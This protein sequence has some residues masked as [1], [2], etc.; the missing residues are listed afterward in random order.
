M[1][2]LFSLATL[3]G[4][5]QVSESRFLLG[6]FNPKTHPDFIEIPDSLCDREGLTLQKKVLEAYYL[7]YEAAKADSIELVIRSAT[8][9]FYYQKRIWE[10]KWTGKR[11]VKGL[12][13]CD[14]DR[15]DEDRA[16]II[17]RYS[18]MPGTSRH[19]WG[20]EI[21]LNNFSNGYF[22][23]GEGLRIY[24]WLKT[25][26]TTYGFYQ[27]YTAKD[28]DR[29]T[30]YEEE[31]WHWSYFPLSDEYT[32]TYLHTIGDQQISGFHGDYTASF[33]KVIENYVKG[34]AKSP[35]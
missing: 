3:S 2:L 26:A 32:H 14:L 35:K 11:K 29:P 23:K 31:K 28:S 12:D 30:G 6:K 27:P 19:H 18:S 16:L 33:I 9:N 5:A 10:A 20:T 13:T 25:H 1:V 4:L 34:V 17:L 21:D 22:E 8:R 7:M 15:T 24:E